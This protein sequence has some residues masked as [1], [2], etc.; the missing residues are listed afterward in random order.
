MNDA[1]TEQDN[2]HDAIH[3]TESTSGP[4]NKNQTQVLEDDP[5]VSWYDTDLNG[6]PAPNWVLRHGEH[7]GK[8]AV[9]SLALTIG[10][11]VWAWT[12]QSVVTIYVLSFLWAFLPPVSFWWEFFYVYRVYGRPGTFDLFKHGQQASAALWAAIVV[13]LIFL[14]NS[15]RFKAD[16]A[17]KNPNATSDILQHS[18]S[19]LANKTTY[20]SCRP[21]EYD[22]N[23]AAAT[24]EFSCSSTPKPF[25]VARDGARL[26]KQKQI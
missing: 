8:F 7:A 24:S 25:T 16:K 17:P 9:A 13:I 20:R 12:E 1:Q 23:V 10:M 6:N 18:D 5:R 2:H 14:A 19:L 22:I 26:G 4:R 3:S 21:V 15:D 11:V